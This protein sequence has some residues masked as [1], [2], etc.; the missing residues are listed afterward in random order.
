MVREQKQMR[1]WVATNNHVLI[2]CYLLIII[3][4][5]SFYPNNGMKGPISD[6]KLLKIYT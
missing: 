6:L 4:D 3:N 2:M 1:P 5:D